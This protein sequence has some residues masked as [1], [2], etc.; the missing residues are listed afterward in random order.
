MRCD[1][2]AY[3]RVTYARLFSKIGT[4]YGVGDGSTTFNVP[5][6]YNYF[7]RGWD[8]SSAFNTVQQDQVG[9]HTHTYSGVTGEE[10][11]H[12]H[13]RGDMNI[14]G[15]ITATYGG[16]TSVSGAFTNLRSPS[17]QGSGGS[18]YNTTYDFDASNSWTGTTS[19]GSAH[20]HS[21]TGTTN[22]NATAEGTTETRVLNK[23]L[24][25]VI[26]Y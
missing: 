12:T 16:V 1:G 20:S 23:M 18:S 19:G 17:S 5:N 10:S 9:K 25:P 14:T 11:A 4:T 2:S 22:E 21:F 15:S 26:K 8:G 6:L 13:T 3:N 24:V 7:I